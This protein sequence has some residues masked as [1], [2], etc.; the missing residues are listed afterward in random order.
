MHVL[1]LLMVEKNPKL[2]HQ[3]NFDLVLFENLKVKIL[4]DLPCSTLYINNYIYI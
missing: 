3:Q 2:P 1:F 4:L